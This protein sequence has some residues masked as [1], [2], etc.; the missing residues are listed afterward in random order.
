MLAAQAIHVAELRFHSADQRIANV[1]PTPHAAS[2]IAAYLSLGYTQV[3]PVV[4]GAASN[5][6]S[7]VAVLMN[8]AE[9]IGLVVYRDGNVLPPPSPERMRWDNLKFA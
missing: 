2:A 4:C 9:E 8:E 5:A 7:P 3:R 6:L 1:A